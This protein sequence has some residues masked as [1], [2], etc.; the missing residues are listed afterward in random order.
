MKIIV[1]TSDKYLHLLPIF[2]F[3]FNKYWG[4][5]Y[6]VE[7]VGYHTPDCFLPSNFTFYSLGE[8]RG[9]NRNFSNDLLLYFEKQDR[10]FIWMMEDTFLKA[11][12][13]FDTLD[14]CRSISI[15]AEVGRVSLTNDSFKQYTEIYYPNE[16]YLYT[17]YQLP[18]LS[19]YRLSTQPAIWKKD[20]LLQYLTK[21]L[22]PWEF[23]CQEKKL[24]TWKVVCLPKKVSPVAHNEGVRRRDIYQYNFEGIDSDVIE[25]MKQLRII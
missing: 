8:Q 24:D 19:E 23:E 15:E 10:R 25:E 9:D 12:V 5:D 7:I 22:N 20:F 4:S 2:C 17:I 6:H 11:S 14:M 18:D 3:L 13:N 21:N 16:E 1:T